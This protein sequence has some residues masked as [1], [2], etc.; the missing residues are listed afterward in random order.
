MTSISQQGRLLEISGPKG[1][2]GC[3]LTHVSGFEAVFDEFQFDATL[4]AD[5][6]AL[7]KDDLLGKAVT[8]KLHHASS[9]TKTF[10]GIVT[11]FNAGNIDYHNHR[12]YSLI[13]EPWFASL[14]L[15]S[16]CRIF[17]NLT[18]PQIFTTICKELNFT[19]F[20][21]KQLGASYKPL[22]Y[23]VQYNETS[24]DFLKRLLASVGIYY[25]YQHTS[26]HHILTLLDS[27]LPPTKYSEPV[28]Y[29]NHH[30]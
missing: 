8:I 19:N 30:H 24:Y 6:T 2:S 26:E 16:D 14:K 17:Q 10:N 1:L 15:V 3:V 20:E 13:I 23:C 5:N 21:I 9:G 7:N 25:I 29:T 28:L 12:S 4:L 11:E 27:S 22:T 18:I